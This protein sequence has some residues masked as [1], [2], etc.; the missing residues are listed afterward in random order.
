MED[1]EFCQEVCR[2]LLNFISY[3]ALC[4][5]HWSYRCLWPTVWLATRALPRTMICL[6]FKCILIAFLNRPFCAPWTVWPPIHQWQ[7]ELQRAFTPW[8][9]HPDTCLHRSRAPTTKYHCRSLVNLHLH[10]DQTPW[11]ASTRYKRALQH[12]P[13][14]CSNKWHLSSLACCNFHQCVQHP[15][16]FCNSAIS[17]TLPQLLRHTLSS[18][19]LIRQSCLVDHKIVCTC[20]RPYP[21]AIFQIHISLSE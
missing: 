15:I 19:T 9:Y 2:T 4:R 5:C 20:C 7:I 10:H 21:I 6:S 1:L 13:E 18:Y 12:Q 14:A 8:P 3:H 17:T 11:T 16:M